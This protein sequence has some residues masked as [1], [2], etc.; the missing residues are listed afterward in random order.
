MES[1]AT[2][3][4]AAVEREETENASVSLLLSLF[5]SS[6]LCKRL[7]HCLHYAMCESERGQ[8]FSS[9]MRA[10]VEGMLL[11]K[12]KIDFSFFFLLQSLS[13]RKKNEE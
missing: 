1:S 5:L 11:K 2:T 13:E 3:T 9:S 10:G 8:L 12:K 7:K 4:A 6:S